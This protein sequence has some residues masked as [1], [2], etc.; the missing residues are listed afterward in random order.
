ME[1][2][3]YSMSLSIFLN[4]ATTKFGK[5]IDELSSLLIQIRDI[6]GIQEFSVDEIRHVFFQEKDAKDFILFLHE[7]GYL[8]ESYYYYCIA[9]SQ[10]DIADTIPF[11]CVVCKEYVNEE[12]N[13]DHRVR[14]YYELR[15]DFIEELKRME[16]EKLIEIIG[17]E[18]LPNF[19][20]LRANKTNLIPFLGAGVSTPF[21]LPS[22]GDMFRQINTYISSDRREV[23]DELINEGDYFGA[24]S[25][26]KE[27][28]ATLTKD[29][30][31]QEHIAEKLG[32]PNL[33]LSEDEHNI[34][35]LMNL[36]CD[37]YLTTNYDNILMNFVEGVRVPSLLLPEVENVHRLLKERKSRIIH[38]HGN[39]ERPS[40]M[41]VTEENYKVLYDN[42]KYTDIMKTIMGNKTLVYIGF[43]FKDKFFVN[44]HNE[45][46]KNVGGNHFL[47]APDIDIFRARRLSDDSNL[48][49]I[50]F[51][52][53]KGENR[54]KDYVRKLKYILQ[55][56]V[57]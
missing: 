55:R 37:F 46:T 16:D 30:H 8:D 23:F 39:L 6:V 18:F 4:A 49:V 11:N 19:T 51:P 47:I 25:Y 43:S 34:K 56:L 45:I 5:S 29:I 2:I 52:L 17:E 3:C 9:Y 20:L 33:D 50:S 44:L 57:K 10:H 14:H 32:S 24:C 38:V 42:D 40:T 22:W 35:D 12:S 7:S 48:R 31:I 54:R 1:R 27:N 28:S 53:G 15:R 41:I 26:L 21:G 13:V 36:N